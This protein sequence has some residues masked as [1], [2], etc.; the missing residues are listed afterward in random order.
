MDLLLGDVSYNQFV[1]CYMTDASDGQDSTV[2][3]TTHWP[4]DVSDEDTL[5]IQRFPAAYPID[6][7][8][9]GVRDLIVAPNATFEIDGRFGSWYYRNAGSEAVPEWT[10]STEAFLQEGMIDLGRGAYPAFTD[11]DGDG[12]MDMVVAN[13]ERYIGPGNTPS[14]LARFRNVGTPTAPAFEQLDTNWLSLS[15]YS[16]ES[17]SLAFGDLDGDGDDD[18]VL[19]DELGNLHRWENTAAPGT[20]MVLVLAD[21]AMTDA[22]GEAIDVGQFATPCLYDLDAD[23]DLDLLV[24]EKNG[25]LNLLE[26]TGNAMAPSFTS[27][28]ASAGQV[29][30]DNLLG[31]NGFAVPHVWPTDSGLNLLVGN[32]L[33]RLQL[34]SLPDAPMEEPDAEWTEVTGQWLGLYEGE[35]AAPA[36]ADLDADGTHDLVVGVRD[37]GLTLWNGQA[38][39]PAIS[40]CSSDVIDGIDSPPVS[41]KAWQ[42]YPNPVRVGYPLNVPSEGVMVMDL[43]GRR[44]GQLKAPSGVV[45]WPAEWG[46][47]TY[48]LAPNGHG[49]STT[50][51]LSHRK[52]ARRLVIIDP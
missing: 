34:Y 24:G 39:E 14:L 27:V 2:A 7:D 29:L 47:G 35:F 25:N 50:G 21:P 43:T 12:D 17:V 52:G 26:N 4:A 13:K 16:L 8:Q 42:P 32:E 9:D 30:A 48:L 15:D 10:L 6:V 3:T 18:L 44:L 5:D 37:G 19:G 33:G 20:D 22:A 38:T 40:G 1:A 11:F 36:L 45:I 28:T 31:I 41:T 51:A 46:P 23:G 49:S